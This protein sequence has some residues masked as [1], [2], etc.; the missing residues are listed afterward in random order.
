MLI[1][2][3]FVSSANAAVAAAQLDRSFTLPDNVE[4]GRGGL[5]VERSLL[6]R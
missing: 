2:A 4:H 3:S 5:G 1:G 6:G